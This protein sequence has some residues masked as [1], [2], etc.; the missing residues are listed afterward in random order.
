MRSFFWIPAVLFCTLSD[1]AP[2]ADAVP[3]AELAKPGRLLMLRHANAPGTGDPSGFKLDDCST[4]RNLDQAGQ[5]QASTLGQRLQKAGVREVRVYSS[6]W[7]RCL[8]T[9]RLLKIGTVEPL[10]ALNSFFARSEQRESRLAALRGF[11]S[12]LPTGG[13]PVILVTH[14]VTI[15]AFT[16]EGTVSAGGS[17]FELN[18][19]GAPRL[20]GSI[21]ADLN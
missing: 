9:A 3:L 18:G 1:G 10:S 11:L 7:C 8:D 6:Q 14:Q 17:L 19:S 2:A 13:A 21:V 16:G 5:A 4:Q 20:L 15:T 12:G